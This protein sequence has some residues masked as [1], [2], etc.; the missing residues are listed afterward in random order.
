MGFKD[1]D[2]K[3]M[4]DAGITNNQICSLAGNSICVPVL[5]AIFSQLIELQI[6]K[7]TK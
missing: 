7:K 2:Y 1:V 3:K 5:E 4:R 6:I